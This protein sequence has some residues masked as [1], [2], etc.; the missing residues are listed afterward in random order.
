MTDRGNQNDRKE[1]SVAELAP[2]CGNRLGWN[3]CNFSLGI[4]K[5]LVLRPQWIPYSAHIPYMMASLGWLLVFAGSRFAVM[6]G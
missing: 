4:H 1:L 6:E 3:K 2:P 5:E